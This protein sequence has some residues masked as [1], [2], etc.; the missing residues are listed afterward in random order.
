MAFEGEKKPSANGKH[1]SPHR[2]NDSFFCGGA[3]WQAF[4]EEKGMVQKQGFPA[5]PPF[6]ATC[7]LTETL[8][9]MR[10]E[11]RRRRKTWKNKESQ[12]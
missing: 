12:L 5:T 11:R 6:G 8:F 1:T 3:G 2:S 4:K 10:G 9:V 7:R